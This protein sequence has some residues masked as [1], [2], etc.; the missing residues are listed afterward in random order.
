MINEKDSKVFRRNLSPDLPEAVR[1]GGVWIETSDGKNLLDASGGAV[2][3]NVGHGRESI[4]QAV[5]DQILKAHYAHPTM[6]SNPVVEELAAKL[7]GYAPAGIG[8]FYFMTSG[9]ESVETAIKL[10]RQVH[11]AR[12]DESRFRL[13]SRWKSYHGL[14]LGAL[15]AMGR[16]TFRQPYAPM[17]TEVVHI[18][19]PYCYRCSF[20][21]THPEC[22][23]RCALA[24]EETILNL[25]AE[26]VSAF[27]GETISG[28][29][30]AICPP[31]E[32]YWPL[33]REICDKYGVL[34]IH[35]EVMVGVGRTGK[36]FASG[37]FDTA[38]DIVTLGKG[39]SGGT[40]ALSAVG[41]QSELYETVK[42]GGFVH[43]GT[44]SHHPVGAAAGL[45][46]LNIIEEEGLIERAAI[47]G[48]YLGQALN[49]ALGEHPNVG[50]IS[51]RGMLW[52]IELVQ[53]RETR[54]PF[55]RSDK[56]TERL[57]RK[58]FDNGVLVYKS[59]GL[60]GKDG[61][62]LVLAPPFIITEEQ[63]D[64]AVS[65]IAKSLSEL[66]LN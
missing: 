54:E 34:L 46:T 53:D 41:L 13:I 37:H 5:A 18:P 55:P 3:V 23:L 63:I 6:F 61:D 4:A 12:G 44:Y 19:P 38:P 39:L 8:R 42:A 32:G 26:I 66:G 65:T 45:A 56:L 24:L 17:L 22:G 10:A 52:G 25:G 64:L 50:R 47:Q 57:W 30:L 35:D 15:S 27:L 28:A 21:L 48:E 1:A 40:M 29:T 11:L 59:M 62:G 33:I 2:V 14:S 16:T 49:R 36:F 60:A 58:I 9:S 7:A 43:G 31:P 51:G 20:G